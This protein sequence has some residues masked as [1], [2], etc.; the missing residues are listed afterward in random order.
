MA[1][2][3]QLFRGESKLEAA[4]MSDPAHI[5]QGATGEHVRK[6]QL[7]LIQLDGATL[8]PDGSYGPATARAVLTYKQKRNI[9]NRSYQSQADNI[10][11]KMTIAAL[12]REM[13]LKE[14]EPSDDT[15]RIHCRSFPFPFSP[16]ILNVS[17]AVGG[18]SVAAPPVAQ[19]STSSPRAQ[20]LGRIQSAAIEVSSALNFIRLRGA[21][22]L[23]GLPEAQFAASEPLKALNTHF[24]LDQHPKPLEHLDFLARVYTRIGVVL[25]RA[26]EI[27]ADDPRTGDF[28]N[29]FP[30]GFNEP[31]HPQHG[32]IRFG[33]AYANKGILF[34]TGVIIHEG[35]HFVDR[36]IGHFA[37]ELPPLAGTPVESAK[38]YIQLNSTEAAR[39]AYTYA[40]FALHAFRNFDKR[41]VPFNE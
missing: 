28:A 36:T 35:A 32:K 30:G 18:L 11:G 7:A 14:N 41:I 38:N 19:S 9:V 33:P 13:V 5:V 21:Q 17:F 37:S 31:N 10:V 39:N 6:I 2:Q 15:G 8:K 3:S 25:A 20:A 40:Q 23:S 26:D 16:P 4:A 24:K 1:L 34:Q 12:D 29:A 27:F 22:F